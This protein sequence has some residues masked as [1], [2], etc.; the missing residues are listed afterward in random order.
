MLGQPK[1]LLTLLMLSLLLLTMGCIILSQQTQ[2]AAPTSST[3]EDPNAI[4]TEVAAA[5]ATASS[6]GRMVLELSESQLTAAANEEMKRQGFED[7]QNVQVRLTNGLM[8]ITGQVNQNGIDL[9]LVL[10][11][12]ISVDGQGIPYT[13]IQEGKLGPFPI[14]DNL[15]EQFNVQF[16][17]ILQ[18]QIS[19]FS[20][21]LFVETISINNG[22]I[23]IVA[24]TR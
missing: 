20:D 16:D 15:L 19:D 3:I 6:S 12:S 2:I 8:T 5:A 13:Q 23:T 7:V 21:D 9:P 18:D 1:R 4:L 14:P 24:E 11:L 22:K 10:A 17:Q